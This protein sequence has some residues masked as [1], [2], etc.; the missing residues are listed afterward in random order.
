[1][2]FPGAMLN[3]FRC[4]SDWH[5]P[6]QSA[7]NGVDRPLTAASQG[8]ENGGTRAKD[9]GWGPI[10]FF[11]TSKRMGSFLASATE[12]AAVSA[13]R[14][15]WTKQVGISQAFWTDLPHP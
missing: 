7:N 9:V 1:M 8:A 2:D 15:L 11:N 12:A 14:R 13:G 6:R 3:D 10:F 5:S 4:R